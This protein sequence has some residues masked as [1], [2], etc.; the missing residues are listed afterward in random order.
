MQH[1]PPVASKLQQV[2]FFTMQKIIRRTHR[3]TI[4][5]HTQHQLVAALKSK[6]YCTIEQMF[7]SL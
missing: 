3:L 6:R 5:E 2:S 7:D 4:L 1:F